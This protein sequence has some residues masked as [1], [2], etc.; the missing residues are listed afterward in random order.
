MK[1][2][3]RPNCVSSLDS[4]EDFHIEPL[5]IKSKQAFYLEEALYRMGAVSCISEEKPLGAIKCFFES[6]VFGFKDVLELEWVRDDLRDK[7]E[8]SP[9]GFRFNV[10]SYSQTGYSD[11]GVNRKRIEK[12]RRQLIGARNSLDDKE[13]VQAGAG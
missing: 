9:Q 13:S 6:P 12:L 1:C 11:L 2:G 5:V 7:E 3:S 8:V 4:R 10:R